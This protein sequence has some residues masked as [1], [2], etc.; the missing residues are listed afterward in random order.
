MLYVGKSNCTNATSREL[1]HCF[2]QTFR[3]TGRTECN[4]W[5]I[6][7]SKSVTAVFCCIRYLFMAFSL[8]TWKC[9]CYI[10]IEGVTLL[11]LVRLPAWLATAKMLPWTLFASPHSLS[12]NPQLKLQIAAA[13]DLVDDVFH[14]NIWKCSWNI[15]IKE[16]T[17]LRSAHFLEWLATTKTLPQTPSASLHLFSLS[18]Y[19]KLQTILA[20]LFIRCVMWRCENAAV[21]SLSKGSRCRDLHACPSDSPSPRYFPRHFLPFYRLSLELQND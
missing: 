6:I 5:E 7:T 8:P 3:G 10:P 12:V 4:S 21:I 9:S 18:S 13:S 2:S 19:L 11:R 14:G 17:Q 1:V 15:F 20:S 16:I